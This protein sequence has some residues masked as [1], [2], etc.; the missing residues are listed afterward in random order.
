MRANDS[1]ASRRRQAWPSRPAPSNPG[2]VDQA[3]EI[4]LPDDAGR[5]KLVQLYGKGLRLDEALIDEAVR[6]TSG[7]SAAFIKELM[8]RTAQGAISRDGAAAIMST[9]L[10][11]ALDDMLFA[12]GK[13][14]IKLLGGAR[15]MAPAAEA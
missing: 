4:P 2:R 8:R 7:V 11:E 12:S 1:P 10:N 13:L 5:R 3:I 15:E 6:R 14:N 9:D